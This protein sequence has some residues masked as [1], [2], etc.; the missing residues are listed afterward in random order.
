MTAAI[1]LNPKADG[2][3]LTGHHSDLLGDELE[4]EAGLRIG[5]EGPRAKSEEK[6]TERHAL[7]T[8]R[9]RHFRQPIQD[10]GG[11]MVNSRSTKVASEDFDF[12][13]TASRISFFANSQSRNFAFPDSMAS[14]RPSS[15]SV[16]QAGKA[17]STSADRSRSS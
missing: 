6:E 13:R 8:S 16:C 11:E 17:K 9:D 3:G 5:S 12:H 1:M 10:I 2:E 15:R 14:S 4:L 7:K